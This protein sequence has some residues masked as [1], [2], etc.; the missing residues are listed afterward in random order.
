MNDLKVRLITTIPFLFLI[1]CAQYQWRNSNPSA[2]FSVDYG[3]CSN[4]AI[5]RIPKQVAVQTAVPVNQSSYATNC[6]R[7]AFTNNLICNTKPTGSTADIA[8]QNAAERS[9]MMQQSQ[10]DS[11][12]Q[13][14]LNQYTNN[15]LATKGWQQYRVK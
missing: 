11:Q 6:Y 1:G 9:R 13:S 3:V 14:Q 5:T 7:E 15:C 12:Y 2:N 10:L 4:E 8:A